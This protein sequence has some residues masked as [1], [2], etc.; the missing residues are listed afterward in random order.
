ME[1]LI[2]QPSQMSAEEKRR[3]GQLLRNQVG[4][5]F[6]RIVLKSNIVSVSYCWWSKQGKGATAGHSLQGELAKHDQQCGQ[7]CVS[8]LA[9][10]IIDPIS[11][12]N[13]L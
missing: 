13:Q 3:K 7:V 2:L 4:F 10:K 6:K 1:I 11:Q 8:E 9:E 12:E 5:I